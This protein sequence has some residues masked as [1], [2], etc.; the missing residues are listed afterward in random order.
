MNVI[1]EG[2][3][4]R[5]NQPFLDIMDV[6]SGEKERIWQSAPPYYES[7]SSIFNDSG[8]EVITRENLTVM[9][10]RETAQDVPQFSLV[11]FS[12]QQDAVRQLM[13]QFPH[14]YPHVRMVFGIVCELAVDLDE[15]CAEGDR[16]IQ[17]K[18]WR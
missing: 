8:D 18:R 4:S 11:N 2:A 6:D 16:T 17:K 5:G 1:G 13:T 3:S 9:L 10:S 14:P 15:R 7:F 12:N